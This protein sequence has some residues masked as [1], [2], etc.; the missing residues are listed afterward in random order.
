MLQNLHHLYGKKLSAIDG[1]IGSL[2]DLY[3]D[4]QS[5][6][7]R[8][9]VADT[10]SWLVGRLTLL[11]PHALGAFNQI[12]G[13]LPVHLTRSQI[14][15]SPNIDQHQPISRQHEMS[16]F[17]Y[18][19]WPAYWE[20][21]SLWGPSSYP[22]VIDASPWGLTPLERYH[23]HREDRHL[24]SA[25]DLLG[26]SI[27]T[28]DGVI[29]TLVDLYF[30]DSQWRINELI[31]ETGSWYSGKRIR[32]LPEHIQRIR[33]TDSTIVVKLTKRDLTDAA[34]GEVAHHAAH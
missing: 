2:K 28:T 31:V 20:G 30:D 32:L 21:A 27:H 3:F 6:V 9:V 1:E 15:N 13:E 14:E 19:G 16:Y 29:G 33:Y 7:I 8:Y 25:R 11:S 12:S 10:G 18:Y 23:Q 34:H 4:D 22:M 17:G 24:Q 5:W 26:Y